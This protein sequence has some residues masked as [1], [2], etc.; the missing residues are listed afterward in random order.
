MLYM[1]KL[2]TI[3]FIAAVLSGCSR[4][5]FIPQE[6]MVTNIK[7]PELKYKDF[8]PVREACQYEATK[9]SA[10]GGGDYFQKSQ[11]WHIVLMAC[12]HDKGWWVRD[13]I[14]DDWS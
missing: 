14:D 4:K 9:I 10:S 1:K 6:W 12:L 13:S 11:S 5:T 8:V 3:L 2:I 7:N